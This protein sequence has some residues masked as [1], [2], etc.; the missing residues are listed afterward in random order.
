MVFILFRK[1][2]EEVLKAHTVYTFQ[3]EKFK[4]NTNFKFIQKLSCIKSENKTK[5]IFIEVYMT[6]KFNRMFRNENTGAAKVPY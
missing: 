5:Q 6:T 2:N 4:T 1:Q 3:R